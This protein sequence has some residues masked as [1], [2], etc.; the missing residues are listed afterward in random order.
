M[1]TKIVK[2]II[3]FNYFLDRL[4]LNMIYKIFNTD[5]KALF[6]KV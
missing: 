3:Y 5:K 6:Y 1:L 4:D 2:L